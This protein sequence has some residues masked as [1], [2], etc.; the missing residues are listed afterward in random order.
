VADGGARIAVYQELSGAMTTAEVDG[1]QQG[2][3]DR[4]G[5]LPQSVRSLLLL[6]RIKVLARSI[7][8]V[9]VS[10]TQDGIMQLFIEGDTTK[11][12]DTIGRIFSKTDRRVEVVSGP[13]VVL[14][15]ALAAKAIDEQ[16]L[17]V[18]AILQAIA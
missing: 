4:F 14:S 7:G 16:A 5:A 11:I 18:G 9:K 8:S 17:E 13:P 1:V 2:L 15:T 3:I 6:M 12:H 10:I